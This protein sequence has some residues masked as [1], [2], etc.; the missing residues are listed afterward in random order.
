MLS[1]VFVLVGFVSRPSSR[2]CYVSHNTP[3]MKLSFCPYWWAEPHTAS[4]HKAGKQNNINKWKLKR[5]TILL[6]AYVP[7]T[8][9]TLYVRSRR[10]IWTSNDCKIIHFGRFFII[11]FMFHFVFIHVLRNIFE[12]ERRFRITTGIVTCNIKSK[13]IL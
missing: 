12:K 1:T 13:I 8:T 2:L 5:V 3:W 4:P 6:T 7:T 11:S 9:T 10:N